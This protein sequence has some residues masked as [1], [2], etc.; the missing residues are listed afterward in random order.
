MSVLTCLLACLLKQSL[1]LAWSLPNRLG[2]LATK[3][4]VL[5]IYASPFLAL[6]LSEGQKQDNLGLWSGLL[7]VLLDFSSPPTSYPR[8]LAEYS[9]GCPQALWSSYGR[10]C[11]GR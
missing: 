3:L 5:P 9:N 6:A 4:Q 7:W 8:T 10:K 2:W 11:L 1:S